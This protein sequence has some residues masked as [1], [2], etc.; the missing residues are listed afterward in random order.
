M[1]EVISGPRNCPRVTHAC[2]QRKQLPAEKGLSQGFKALGPARGRRAAA[3][4]AGKLPPNYKSRPCKEAEHK[5]R[6]CERRAQCWSYHSEEDRLG[7]VRL[8]S[9]LCPVLKVRPLVASPQ[10]DRIP[11]RAVSMPSSV[12]WPVESRCYVRRE[13]AILPTQCNPSAVYGYPG[14]F[15]AG[16]GVVRG[17]RRHLLL[18]AHARPA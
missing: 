4:I 1:I 6:D 11:L 5:L 3:I 9:M 17:G 18:C 14:V 2:L 16:D 10:S 15:D 12:T 7:E 8:K 13:A